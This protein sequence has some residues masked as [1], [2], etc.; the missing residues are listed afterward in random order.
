MRLEE[1][2][3]AVGIVT[4]GWRVLASDCEVVFSGFFGSETSPSGSRSTSRAIQGLELRFC[5]RGET[6]IWKFNSNENVHMH[7]LEERKT[8]LTKH[9]CKEHVIIRRPTVWC[10]VTG[11]VISMYHPE[12]AYHPQLPPSYVATHPGVITPLQTPTHEPL[13]SVSTSSPMSPM[14]PLTPM[15]PPPTLSATDLIR[16]DESNLLPPL[17]RHSYHSRPYS[18]PPNDFLNI[19]RFIWKSLF[20]IDPV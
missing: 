7:L 4:V 3:E 9:H 5:H 11:E 2:A 12:I 8:T 1:A 20:A 13:S 6:K 19:L 10:T 14:T 16:I 18:H 15:A 17:H